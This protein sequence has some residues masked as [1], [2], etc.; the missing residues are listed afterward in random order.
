MEQHAVTRL[1]RLIEYN[2]PLADISEAS[3]REKPIRHGPLHIWWTWK[4]P[5]R[6]FVQR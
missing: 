1:K 2:L 5:L 4:R 6:Q 3:A